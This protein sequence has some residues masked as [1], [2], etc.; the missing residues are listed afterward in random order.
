MIREGALLVTRLWYIRMVDPKTQLLT[1]LTRD[2]V[3][4]VENGKIKRALRNYR[5]NQS[6]MRMLAPGN[7]EMIG[8]PVRAGGGIGDRPML[9]PALKLKEFTFTSASEAV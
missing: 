5:F 2:G 8:K 9:C 7:V 1:G 6:V 3:W 4:S